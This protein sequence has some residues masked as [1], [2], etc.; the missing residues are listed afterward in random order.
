MELT[1]MRLIAVLTGVATLCG[2][3]GS[4]RDHQTRAQQTTD[5][6]KSE[7]TLDWPGG[8]RVYMAE[9]KDDSAAKGLGDKFEHRMRPLFDSVLAGSVP[10]GSK[11]S[12]LGPDFPV[13]DCHMNGASRILIQPDGWI[14]F[15]L[16]AKSQDDDDNF[17]TFWEFEDA[18]G[19]VVLTVPGVGYRTY[20]HLPDPPKWYGLAGRRSFDHK[21]Y[22]VSKMVQ[23]EWHGQC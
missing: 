2:C 3:G 8:I 18:Q 15:A 13:G 14:Y 21:K 17:G 16:A 7:K 12:D 11:A 1:S 19:Q 10:P 22:D 6:Q 5:Q 20:I 23:V 4:G 9:S